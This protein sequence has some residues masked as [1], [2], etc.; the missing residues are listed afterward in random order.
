MRV[1]SKAAREKFQ[2]PRNL[3][4]S[5][6]RGGALSFALR[7]AADL[8][9]SSVLKR[10]APWLSGLRGSVL[11]VGCG[12]QP[13]RHFIPDNCGYSALDWEKS[14][15]Y[16]KYKAPD[17]VYYAGGTFPF[18]DNVFDN[19]FHTE[20]IEHVYETEV[21]LHECRRVLKPRGEL[22]FTAPFQARCHYMPNDFWRFT[23]AALERLLTESDFSDIKIY[24][25]GN[26]ITVAAYKVASLAYRWL[27]GNIAEKFLGILSAPIAVAALAAGHI[28]LSA[29]IGSTDDCLGYIVTAKAG[30]E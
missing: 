24:S 20:V 21:F 19:L 6:M 30:M 23:P 7:K 10:L 14:G 29:N 2:P 15:E 17:T 28:S 18:E 12:A 26:D 8:Q 13:Y 22:F 25:R 11:E 3:P 27:M 5:A 1:D 9:V 4:P 16:F